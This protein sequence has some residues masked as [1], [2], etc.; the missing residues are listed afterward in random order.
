MFNFLNLNYKKFYFKKKSIK[1][2]QNFA[3]NKY[4]LNFK[5]FKD[6]DGKIRNLSKE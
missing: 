4:W 3:N 5:K 1:S 6:P 2:V